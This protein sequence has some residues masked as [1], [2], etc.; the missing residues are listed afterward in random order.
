MMSCIAVEQLFDCSWGGT[1]IV[2]T[3]IHSLAW[4]P[5]MWRRF[6]C[7]GSQL[8]HHNSVLTHKKLFA[9][10][11]AKSF[12]CRAF[13]VIHRSSSVHHLLCVLIHAYPYNEVS[14]SRF[15]CMGMCSHAHVVETIAPFF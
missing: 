4:E 5:I 12:F 14:V 6:I 3:S 15:H 1:R 8:L 9:A 7:T 13:D 10:F 2:C 11:A